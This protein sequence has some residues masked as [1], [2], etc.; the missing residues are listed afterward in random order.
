MLGD[1]V[2]AAWMI[3][4]VLI[5][6]VERMMGDGVENFWMNG[7]RYVN[8]EMNRWMSLSKRDP[9]TAGLDACFGCDAP[10]N[11][12]VCMNFRVGSLSCSRNTGWRLP[13]VIHRD[14]RE[15]R[16]RWTFGLGRVREV[17]RLPP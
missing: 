17:G 9:R 6:V 16:E 15:N 4:C 11:G 7:D 5:C 12:D 10:W 14:F 8:V 1:G 2:V 3:L 13:V